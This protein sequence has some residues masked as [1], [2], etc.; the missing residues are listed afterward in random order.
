MSEFR[1]FRTIIGV[2]AYT[3]DGKSCTKK[4]HEDYSSFQWVRGE[5]KKKPRPP[6]RGWTSG[7]RA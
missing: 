6:R 3:V 5:G 4:A 1:E 7:L 2:G